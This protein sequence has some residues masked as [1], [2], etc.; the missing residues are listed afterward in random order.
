MSGDQIRCTLGACNTLEERLQEVTRLGRSG[1]DQ[2]PDQP[3]ERARLFGGAECEERP[4]DQRT[5][6]SR[7][8]NAADEALEALARREDRR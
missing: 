3:P 7:S 6:E 5:N 8:K 2:A 4:S 1:N